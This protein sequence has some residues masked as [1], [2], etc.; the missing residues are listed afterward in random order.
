[1]AAFA[2]R[3]L[4][5][6]SRCADD[7]EAI[8]QMPWGVIV[9]VCGVTVLIAV[10]EKAEGIDL[11]VSQIAQVRDADSRRRWPRSD[12]AVSVYSSTSGVVLPA[13]LPMVP[14]LAHS[15]AAPPRLP[16]PRR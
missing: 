7:R 10:L 6:L 9:M 12:R 15:L 4:L 16:S 3:V 2:G 14:A 11:I 13:F 1:M 8:R 5:V